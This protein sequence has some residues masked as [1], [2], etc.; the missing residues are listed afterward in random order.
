M[1]VTKF[2]RDSYKL[3]D[4]LNTGDDSHKIGRAYFGSFQADSLYPEKENIVAASLVIKDS[5]K[6]GLIQDNNIYLLGRKGLTL[7]GHLN[8]ISHL[9]QDYID[10]VLP[11]PLKS[12]KKNCA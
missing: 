7:N 5:I 3:L 6:F 8:E 10:L 11:S 4:Y 2:I 1:E 9:M 12:L